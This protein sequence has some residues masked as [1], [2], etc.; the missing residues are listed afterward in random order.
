M[1]NN[2]YGYAAGTSMAAPHVLGV[3]ALILDAVGKNNL[4][5]WNF[6]PFEVKSA[7][8]RSTVNSPTDIVDE[9][10]NTY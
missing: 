6:H 10:D 5:Q 8:I 4:G 9:P 1:W 3:A 2:S 7:I